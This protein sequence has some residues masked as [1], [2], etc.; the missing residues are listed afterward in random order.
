MQFETLLATLIGGFVIGFLAQR[1]RTCFIGGVRDYYL[2]RD[3]Y[4]MKGAI[5]FLLSALMAFL[6]LRL[7]IGV[8]NWP[9][10]FSKALLPI[11]GSP[12]S[13]M[14]IAGKVPLHIHLALAM[15]GGFG[16]GLF[17]V[18]AGGCPLRQHVMASEGN[19][20]SMAYLLGFYVAAIAF[21]A[22]MLPIISQV[23]GW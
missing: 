13:S 18:L 11:P 8:P 6:I 10:I 20:S 21:H 9:W 15:I 19:K 14:D 5:S 23:L 3:S 7:S 1:T 12:L 16:I 4:L 2:V 17:S 22:F